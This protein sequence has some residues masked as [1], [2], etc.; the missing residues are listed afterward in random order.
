MGKK[1]QEWLK[2]KN[3]I[4]NNLWVQKT[5]TRKYFELNNYE[6][7]TQKCI[8]IGILLRRNLIALNAHIRKE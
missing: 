7:V 1:I 5:H 2:I 4:L 3:L 8:T 6:D